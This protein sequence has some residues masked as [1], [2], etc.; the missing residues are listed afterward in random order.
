MQNQLKA[1]TIGNSTDGNSYAV[2]LLEDNHGDAILVEEYLREYLSELDLVHTETFK[3]AID[4]IQSRE[5]AF[6]AILLDL[7]L[8]D[9]MGTDLVEAMLTEAGNTP[10]IVLTG[11]G[12]EAFSLETLKMGVTDYLL[13][14]EFNA[15][16]LYKSLL[17]GIEKNRI[18]RELDKTNR[19]L[20]AAIDIAR[21][22]RW[23][24]DIR[25]NAFEC[26]KEMWN[27]LG[28]PGNSG[29]LTLDAY[30]EMVLNDDLDTFNNGFQAM[31]RSQNACEI[32][33]RIATVNKGMK[34]VFLRGET[35]VDEKKQVIGVEGVI[36]DIS[37]RKEQE[38][39]RNILQSVITHANDTVIITQGN[40]ID[41]PGPKIIYVNQAFTNLTG[42]E[43]EEVLGKSPRILQGPDTSREELDRLREALEEREACQIEVVNYTKHGHPYWVEMS[44]VPIL[45]TNGDCTHF[46][47]IERD[48]IERKKN[49]QVLIEL[50]QIL[51]HQVASRT[52]ELQDAHELL[53]YHYSELKDS[54]IYAQSVQRS[55]LGT[56][57]HLNQLFPMSFIM[58]ESRDLVS[59][60][61]MWCH[62][63]G[64][65]LK[66]AAVA[67]CTGHGLPGALLSMIAH[68]L[69]NQSVKVKP[70]TD[71]AE[72]LLS[73]HKELLRIYKP[74]KQV[75]YQY[76]GMDVGLMV[77]DT[78]RSLVHFCGARQNLYCVNN[79]K[80]S[81]VRGN[82]FTI[83]EQKE[84][85]VDKQLYTHKFTYQS[86]DRFY[87]SS[88]GLI[89]QF[90]GKNGKK[91][92]SK[93]FVKLLNKIS[94]LEMSQQGNALRNAFL[95]WKKNQDQ[96]DD[97]LVM[98]I[99]LSS[100]KSK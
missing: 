45:D 44:V 15:F 67:D 43:A 31:I 55:I 52:R 87:L 94:G 70:L 79:G 5:S 85:Q 20:F 34:H 90:G 61:F 9:K 38:E 28:L 84:N 3:G 89:D 40:E 83:G 59:G 100:S 91:L 23:H 74:N 97:V 76:N 73:V 4:T 62:D 49:E 18:L 65:G 78:N 36:Q 56:E 63:R 1:Q 66:M 11:Y 37:T 41:E 19:T 33:H 51:E 10:I 53:H 98:G 96:T 54:L 46:I 16:A 81:R 75:T 24:F 13:K 14:G 17:Y 50:T 35:I 22:G 2:L 82:K 6:D 29:C 8:P 69:L 60:D 77:I 26:S 21:L 57:S 99:D 88:D 12:D 68:Q 64:D 86:G 30:A 58:A 25:K 71:P 80:L 42:Y 39:H 7:S 47:S 32:E 27:L 92:M 93:G 95:D 72:I 48:V